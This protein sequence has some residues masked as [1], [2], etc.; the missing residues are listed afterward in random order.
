MGAFTLNFDAFLG[1][2]IPSFWSPPSTTGSGG[3]LGVKHA[4]ASRE[5][6]N[7]RVFASVARSAAF[8][9]CSAAS[10]ATDL[11]WIAA[12]AFSAAAYNKN[13]SDMNVGVLFNL[14]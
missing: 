8:V 14:S 11:Q 7:A 4:I 13:Q 10:N 2:A 5:A 12:P 3:G 1:A 9:A 6:S